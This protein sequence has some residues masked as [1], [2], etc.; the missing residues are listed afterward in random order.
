MDIKIKFDI[1]LA[2]KSIDALKGFLN[3]VIG[4]SAEELGLM[5]QDELRIRRLKNQVKN[6]TRVKEIVE[7][8]NISVKH[9]NLKALSPYLNGVAVEED[10]DLQEIWANM[11]VNYID[12]TR[13]LTQTVYPQI[14]QQ[15]SS[16]E[17]KIMLTMKSN[18][19][20]LKKKMYTENEHRM[21]FTREDLANL[22]RLGLVERI[23]QFSI[24]PSRVTFDDDNYNIQEYLTEDYLLTDFGWDLL[25]S[26]TR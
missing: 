1:P 3:K 21:C 11:F 4:P 25:E 22:E 23:R 8:G 2:E 10:E 19:G 9:I 26:C 20:I 6:L 15:L 14:L 12:A 7:A 18:A 24:H 13:N 5:M 16:L 17:V